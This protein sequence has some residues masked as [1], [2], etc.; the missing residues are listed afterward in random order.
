[1]FSFSSCFRRASFITNL[2]CSHAARSDSAVGVHTERAHHAPRAVRGMFVNRPMGVRAACAAAQDA[3][4]QC[5]QCTGHM[6]AVGALQ[7]CYDCKH[8]WKA[9][10]SFRINQPACLECCYNVRMANP[11][12]G[13]PSA[14]AHS[15]TS[16]P[17][18]P[19]GL[20]TQAPQLGAI[21]SRSAGPCTCRIESQHGCPTGP[22][23][24]SRGDGT[25]CN[26]T[27]EG[28]APPR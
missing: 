22:M 5:R 25:V 10:T 3:A 26:A 27:G 16:L 15:L 21:M 14:A 13:F 20:A 19:A 7:E 23:E 17:T 4:P 1:M 28:G 6:A 2:T 11:E 18:P 8:C 24:S 12:S 9:V